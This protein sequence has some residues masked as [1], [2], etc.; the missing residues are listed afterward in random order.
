MTYLRARIVEAHE[1]FKK[2]LA[3]IKAG[4]LPPEEN[5]FL[6]RSLRRAE[7]KEESQRLAAEAETKGLREEAAPRAAK[8]VPPFRRSTSTE[9]VALPAVKESGM[10]R[11]HGLGESLLRKAPAAAVGATPASV[12]APAT[13]ANSQ[14]SESSAAT[15]T[16]AAAASAAASRSRKAAAA[17]RVTNKFALPKPKPKATVPAT[18]TKGFT[19]KHVGRWVVQQESER[20][21]QLPDH[22]SW[23]ACL[24]YMDTVRS[25]FET[26]DKSDVES[27]WSAMD[28][29]IAKAHDWWE[30]EEQASGL[31][32]EELPEDLRRR[33]HPGLD[34]NSRQA[35]MARW[36]AFGPRVAEGMHPDDW[37][38]EFKMASDPHHFELVKD[39][40]TQGHR[41]MRVGPTQGY[42]GDTREGLEQAELQILCGFM[43]TM[44]Q[45]RSI[46]YLADQAP[47][48]SSGQALRDA[49][50][51]GKSSLLM[52]AGLL[53]APL[54]VSL[55]VRQ[56][57]REPE[58]SNSPRP[59][60]WKSQ[61]GSKL[62]CAFLEGSQADG[63]RHQVNCG[64]SSEGDSGEPSS[65][66]ARGE[67]R[68]RRSLHHRR[69]CSC[70][71]GFAA[72]S[73]Q[74]L[75]YA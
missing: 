41:T 7:R 32:L 15:A 34:I 71:A 20:I 51:K 8:Y 10:P 74:T 49:G 11:S 23:K 62:H 63:D 65:S 1:R 19:P 13:A 69:H 59:Q 30:A 14:G 75:A 72:K 50:Y 18:E 67:E 70:G 45:W 42:Q 48:E 64:Q 24:A 61:A 47:G 52:E 35:I 28:A 56:G 43:D 4:T 40:V 66:F 5:P 29:C 22:P 16:A 68:L 60:G 12:A 27:M 3:R 17:E 44:V 37:P 38:E 39:L 58:S 55:C 46:S 9:G 54:S 36:V 6:R 57:H 53:I 26:M 73:S 33:Y 2:E 31:A 21:S 25:K